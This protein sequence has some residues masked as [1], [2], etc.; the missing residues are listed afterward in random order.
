MSFAEWRQCYPFSSA[1]CSKDLSS[2]DMYF[3]Q[4]YQLY[5]LIRLNVIY[6]PRILDFSNGLG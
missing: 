5:V 6:S 2:I 1:Q 3:V 4:V